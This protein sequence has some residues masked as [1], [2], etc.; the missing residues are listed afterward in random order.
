[1]DYITTEQI[2]DSGGIQES[3]F[4]KIFPIIAAVTGQKLI[5]MYHR[6]DIQHR[7]HRERPQLLR[8]PYKLLLSQEPTSGTLWR[9]CVIIK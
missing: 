3:Q 9:L 4:F 7:D 6:H 2:N 8:A 5:G 1:M